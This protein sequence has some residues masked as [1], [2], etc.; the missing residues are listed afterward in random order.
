MEPSG[1]PTSLSGDALAA[2]CGGW[3]DADLPVIE[4]VAHC[5]ATP[6]LHFGNDLDD[7]TPLSWTRS[8]ARALGME[9]SVVRYQ[10]GGHTA[11]FQRSQCIAAAMIEY[12]FTRT[13]P[14]GL[15]CP[16]M[17]IGSGPSAAAAAR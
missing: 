4:N 5:V 13:V 1:L 9:A 14:D 8:L 2:R 7:Q 6:V 3:P 12:L 17:P 15:V 11:F 10:G 16:A